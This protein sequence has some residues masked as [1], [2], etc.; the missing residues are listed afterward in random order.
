VTGADEPAAG[1]ALCL[2]LHVVIGIVR[3]SPSLDRG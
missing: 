1:A 2:C 3:V